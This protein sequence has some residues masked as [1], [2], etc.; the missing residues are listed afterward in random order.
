[1]TNQRHKIQTGSPLTLISLSFN[2]AAVLVWAFHQLFTLFD[3]DD[4]VLFWRLVSTVQKEI[5]QA[6][7]ILFSVQNFLQITCR[8]LAVRR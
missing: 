7:F 4:N 3:W 2:T 1:V 8:R 5:V 6:T